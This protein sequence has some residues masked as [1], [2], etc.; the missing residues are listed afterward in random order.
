MSSSNNNDEKKQDHR[1]GYGTP[2]ATGGRCKQLPCRPSRHQSVTARLRACVA[3][4]CLLSVVAAA[5]ADAGLLSDIDYRVGNGL[6]LP[7]LGLTLGG[8]ATVTYESLQGL[9]ARTALDNLSLSVWWEGP[10]HWKVFSEF[11]IENGLSS[12]SAK[13]T[14]E[15]Q[16]LALERFYVDYAANESTTVR[17]GKFLTPI[18][19]WNLLHATPLVWTTSRPLVTTLAFPTNATGLMVSGTVSAAGTPVDY[20]VY[21]SG[22]SEVR[23]NP[24]LNTFRRAMGTHVTVPLATG[25]QLGFSYVS[26]SQQKTAEEHDQLVGID[27]L[28]SRGGYELTAEAIHKTSN[29]SATGTERGAFVQLA[30]PLSGQLHAVGRYEVYHHAQQ[31]PATRVWVTGLSLRVTPAIVLKAEW[32]GAKH[33][34]TGPSE[35]FLTSISV[36]F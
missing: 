9:P 1:R 16:Y 26:F 14:D 11:N 5:Q 13:A 30:A 27:F 2:D 35:G 22:G 21:G 20:S 36:L 4:T 15:K 32:I 29:Q 23:P 7:G 10:S 8:Y 24:A 34:D 31:G 17:V 33:N 12:R 25:T 3:A 6:H 19:R 28:W 18:G